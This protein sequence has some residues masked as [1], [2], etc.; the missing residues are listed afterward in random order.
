MFKKRQM[1]FDLAYLEYE[2]YNVAY[3]KIN[4][5]GGLFQLR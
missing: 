2:I 5:L 1:E 3:N 4:Y